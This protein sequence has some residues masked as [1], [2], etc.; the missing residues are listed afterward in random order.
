MGKSRKRDGEGKDRWDAQGA[1]RVAIAGLV[2][3]TLHG[4]SH[5]EAVVLTLQRNETSLCHLTSWNW[6]K[7][8]WLNSVFNPSSRKQKNRDNL[9]FYLHPQLPL[10]R[11]KESDFFFLNVTQIYFSSKNIITEQW[12]HSWWWKAYW[13]WGRKQPPC[14]LSPRSVEIMHILFELIAPKYDLLYLLR[15]DD[16]IGHI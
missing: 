16:I 3:L 7:A 1:Q 15:V 10:I 5:L 13:C 9:L 12:P 2:Y 4:S 6:V 11:V 8:G 14:V